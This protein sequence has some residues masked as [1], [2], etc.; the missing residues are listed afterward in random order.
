[1]TATA[2][3][4]RRRVRVLEHAAGMGNVAEIC[5]T[6]GVSRKTFYEWKNLAA[7]YGLEVL[8]PSGGAA[9]AGPRSSVH[10]L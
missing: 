7:G 8:V 4:Y 9:L 10:P 6:F 2:I 3:I 5:R 1:V